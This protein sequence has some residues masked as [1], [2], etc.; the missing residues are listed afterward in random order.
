MNRNAFLVAKMFKGLRLMNKYALY[1][2]K[3]LGSCKES[4]SSI[5]FPNVVMECSK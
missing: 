1:L 4:E 5:S 3:H 2:I